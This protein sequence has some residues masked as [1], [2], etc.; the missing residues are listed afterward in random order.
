M[1]PSASVTLT[2]RRSPPNPR[3]LT[4]TSMSGTSSNAGTSNRSS[5]GSGVSDTIRTMPWMS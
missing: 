5:S 1:W 3:L 2:L 4:D